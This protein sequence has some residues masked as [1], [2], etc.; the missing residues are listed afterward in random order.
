[1]R[2]LEKLRRTRS[3]LRLASVCICVCALAMGVQALAQTAPGSVTMKVEMVNPKAGQKGARTID[4]GD[5]SN[6]VVWLTPLDPG[7]KVASAASHAGP[8]P[9]VAQ[10]NKSF[11]PR[12][13]VIQM[14][15]A[16]QFPNKD[17]Y[18]HNVFSLFD[19]KRFDLGFYEAGSSKTVPFDR[20]GVSF[21]FCNI[22]PEMSAAIVAVDTPY[23]AMS[24]R[25]G[26]VN[27]PKVPEGRYQ[28]NVWYERSLPDDLK[29]AG[30][31]VTISDATRTLEPIRVVEN[32]DFTLEHKNKYG[33]EYV[34]PANNSPGYGHP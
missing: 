16:V 5:A 28:L 27:I 10:K 2:R 20:A 34:P 23:F 19:G 25:S 32:P 30:R 24:D 14:G 8:M 1:M 3:E 6:V 4:S 13:L 15:T 17:P 18:L 11:E 21:L 31:V 7:A 33:Q 26:R 12:V 29:N 22:H 9:Q